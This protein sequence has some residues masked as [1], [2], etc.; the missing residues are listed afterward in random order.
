[1]EADRANGLEVP[2]V[3]DIHM[4]GVNGQTFSHFWKVGF[5]FSI[6]IFALLIFFHLKG[7][8]HVSL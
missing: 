5:F 7:E 2:D 3:L 6:I 8:G 1:M 4:E